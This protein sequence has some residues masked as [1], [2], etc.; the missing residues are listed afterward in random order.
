M[1]TGADGQDKSGR[2]HNQDLL[3]VSISRF[4]SNKC[5]VQQILPILSGVSRISLRMVDWFV[6]NYSKKHNV[7]IVQM[8]H[9]HPIHFNVHASYRAQLKAYSKQQFDPFRRRDRIDFYYD[10]NQWIETTIGQLNFFRWMLQNQLIEYIDANFDVI[11]REMMASQRAPEDLTDV[12][13]VQEIQEKK[14]RT[15]TP[16]STQKSTSPKKKTQSKCL[17]DSRTVLPPQTVLFD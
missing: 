13:E 11:E 6:T 8:V 3:M 4:Y 9:D 5:H 16:K 1:K 15:K 17:P 7:T 14:S 2:L 10:R 12:Q